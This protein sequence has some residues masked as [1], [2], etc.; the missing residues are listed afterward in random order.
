MNVI[1]KEI[2]TLWVNMEGKFLKDFYFLIFEKV[3]VK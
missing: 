3:K 1:Y 2:I